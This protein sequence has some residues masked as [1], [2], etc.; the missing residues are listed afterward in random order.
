MRRSDRKPVRPSIEPLEGRELLTAML[1]LTANTELAAFD[2]TRP[3]VIS[4][5]VPISGLQ[6]GETLLAIDS[7]AQTGQ[8]YGL[9][10]TRRLYTLN[11]A[12]GQASVVGTGPIAAS[13]TGT[14][15]DI[16]FVSA[17]S[18]LRIVSDGGINLR[19]D[20]DTGAVTIDNNLAYAAT[21]VGAGSTPAVVGL[22]TT[23]NTATDGSFASSFV[24]DAR[25]GVYAL[26]GDPAAI[27]GYDPADG[28]LITNSPLGLEISGK[29][30]FEVTDRA[31]SWSA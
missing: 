9:G 23:G 14:E 8:V 12:T 29:V 25:R 10:S 30:G 11:P 21:D 26:L 27:R 19:V 16:D 15:F 24:I 18:T 17:S 7:R 28:Q 5:L 3:D 2:S 6:P 22:A 20:A 1:G 4:S 13:I 31:N